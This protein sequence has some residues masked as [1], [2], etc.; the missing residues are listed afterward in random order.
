MS[1]TT[2]VI[3]LLIIWTLWFNWQG[4][5][6]KADQYLNEATEN[7]NSWSTCLVQQSQDIHEKTL[8]NTKLYD[9]RKWLRDCKCKCTGLGK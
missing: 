2:H 4:A 6:D 8:C 9:L 3:Y 7:M 5:K 1:R